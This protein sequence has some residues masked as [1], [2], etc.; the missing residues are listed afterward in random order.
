MADASVLVRRMAAADLERVMKLA[1]ALPEAPHWPETA[2]RKALDFASAPRRV[3]LAAQEGSSEGLVGFAIASL[4]PPEAELETIGVATARQR[5]GVGRLL[6]DAL[7]AELRAAGADEIWLEVRASN[8]TAIAFY[9]SLR[10]A[11]NGLRSRYYAD[12]IEDAVRMS[13]RLV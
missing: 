13:L 8:Q 4:L 12:P 7:A 10:F 3:A 6:F 2:Y 9:R 1:E 11:Q 5:R